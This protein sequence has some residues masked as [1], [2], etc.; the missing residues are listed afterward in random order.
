MPQRN[1][2]VGSRGAG[3]AARRADAW[4]ARVVARS[5]DYVGAAANI[6]TRLNARGIADGKCHS[7][8][9]GSRTR[10]KIGQREGSNPSCGTMRT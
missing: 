2:R 1:V 9:T 8:A 5:S 7:G 10:L 3:S 4:T 6:R